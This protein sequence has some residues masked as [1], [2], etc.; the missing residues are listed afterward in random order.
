MSHPL[1]AA[2]WEQLYRR[3]LKNILHEIIGEH[4]ASLAVFAGHGGRAPDM[5]SLTQSVLWIQTLF[6]VQ[7]TYL[8]GLANSRDCHPYFAPYL[9]S[10]DTIYSTLMYLTKVKTDLFPCS[11]PT[12]IEFLRYRQLMG[13]TLLVGIRLL[14]LRGE[15]MNSEA[16]FRL[17]RAMR[18][19]W[20]HPDL[21]MAESFLINDLLP[22]AITSIGSPD[23]FQAQQKLLKASKT[24]IPVFSSGVYPFPGAPETLVTDLMT[25]LMRK[26]NDQLTSFYLLSDL[27]WAAESALIQCHIDRR[28]VSQEQGYTSSGALKVDDAFNQTQD[29]R[30]KLARTILAAYDD[31]FNTPSLQV[32]ATVILGQTAGEHAPLQTRRIRDLWSLLAS[33]RESMDAALGMMVRWLINRR[34]QLWDCNGELEAFSHDYQQHLTQ[35]LQNSTPST[36]SQPFQAGKSNTGVVYVVNC[37]AVH[38][39]PEALLEEQ[40]RNSDRKAYEQ[41]QE[42]SRFL[43]MN[44]TCP[45]CPGSVKIQHARMIEP[46]EQA[47]DNLHLADS[48]S[49]GRSSFPDSTSRHTMSRSSSTTNSTDQ[50]SRMDSVEALRS[51]VSPT[52]QS[53][54]FIKLSSRSHSPTISEAPNSFLTRPRTGQPQDK[55]LIRSL[56]KDLKSVTLSLAGT[57]SLFR[58]NSSKGQH[59][60]R[61]PRFGFSTSGRCLLLWETASNWMMRF[62]VSSIDG[63]KAGSHRY[64]VTGVQYATAGNNRCAVIASAAEHYE[65]LIFRDKGLIP[66]SYLTIEAPHQNSSISCM[67]MSR[68]DK[69]VA[70]TFNDQI[71][72]YEIGASGIRQV[73]LDGKTDYYVAGQYSVK[74]PVGNNSEAETS[75]DGKGAGTVIGRR[76]QFSV[77][78]RRFIVATHLADGY[79]YVDVWNCIEHQWKLEPGGSK[80]FK[81]PPWT[82][83][84]EDLTCVFYDS[85][86]ETVVL[87]AFLGKEYP[88]SFTLSCE[89]FISDPVSPRIVHAAQSPSGS[90]FVM[91]NG[92]KQM[93]LCD[94]TASG[95]LIPTKMKKAISKINAAAFR[96]TQLALSFPGEN[97]VFA[98]WAKEG[99]LMLRTISLHAGGETV[100]DCDLRSEFDRLLVE[101]P[102]AGDFHRPRHQ[103]SSLSRQIDSE[104]EEFRS[105]PGPDLVELPAT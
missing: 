33:S 66:E 51:P 45:L 7:R 52:S 47:L 63:K 65:L 71:R 24:F 97:E 36:S 100:S 79:A 5:E 57:T 88:I 94:S 102:M 46:F 93:F 32:L 28:R 31:E 35:W 44:T 23:V 104:V 2:V 56:S 76:L 81:L 42:K 85:F 40:L 39:V 48:E 70:F 11:K 53:H 59:L 77:D 68:D 89:A 12:A 69:Y 49:S 98:F 37:P 1:V 54:S 14:L 84:D 67:V 74:P 41:F 34:V 62:E 64:D 16:K 19:A 92:L 13:H 58:R 43:T 30:K 18:S 101:R 73:Q 38:P 96:P 78:G 80:S 21:S 60:P 17:E 103:P 3:D 91:A 22:K 105:I 8:Q 20:E 75:R 95:S 86:N 90:R 87:T 26:N 25:A 15:A 27:L 10:S 4:A 72:V 29:N 99:K 6:N 55:P 9:I 50:S 83:D 61:L 82:D